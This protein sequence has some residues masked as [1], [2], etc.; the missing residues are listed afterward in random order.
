MFLVIWPIFNLNCSLLDS[1]GSATSNLTIRSG[2]KFE[3]T[4]DSTDPNFRGDLDGDWLIPFGFLPNN[5]TAFYNFLFGDN[6]FSFTF[7]G[8]KDFYFY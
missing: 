1:L 7:G 4:D 5:L 3:P 6:E 8:D 2:D